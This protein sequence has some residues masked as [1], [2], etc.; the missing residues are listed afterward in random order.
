VAPVEAAADY[1]RGYLEL[2]DGFAAHSNEV[3]LG[4]D[5]I[6][7]AFT[8]AARRGEDPASVSW[9][10]GGVWLLESVSG[11][12]AES[13]RV[14]VGR[15]SPGAFSVQFPA[16]AFNGETSFSSARIVERWDTDTFTGSVEI[17][18]DG[19]PFT[20]PDPIS[21]PISQEVTLLVPVLELGRFLG[22]AEWQATGAELG[23]TAQL[24]ATLVDADGEVVGSYEGF[25][26][27]FPPGEYGVQ[28]IY[29]SE[30]FPTSQEGAVAVSLEY[31][32]GV[33]RMSPVSIGFDL[34]GVPVGR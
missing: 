24:V 21:I 13:T 34:E 20:A 25:P 18:F 11:T 3:I 2:V 14:V 19:E 15:F 26:E 23:V 5:V 12:T 27:N 32:V 31:T 7:V 28:E 16:A 1:P 22:S 29:W 17:P 4:D 9:P 8:A 33:A 30:P 10:V 6:T